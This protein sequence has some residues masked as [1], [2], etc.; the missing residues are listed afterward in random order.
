M[1]YVLWLLN[2]Q[3]IQYLFIKFLLQVPS[4]FS[5]LLFPPLHFFL[6]PSSSSML[7]GYS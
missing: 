6:Q 7:G 2:F 1:H 5:L 4:E 3:F